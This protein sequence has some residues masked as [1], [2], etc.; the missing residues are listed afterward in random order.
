MTATLVV[1]NVVMAIALWWKPRC[2]VFAFIQC[3][4][5]LEIYPMMYGNSR[6]WMIWE[7][8]N[9][10]IGLI[11]IYVTYDLKVARWLILLWCFIAAN[12]HFDKDCAFEMVI[13]WETHAMDYLNYVILLT[14]LVYAFYQP[15]LRLRS[16][17]ARKPLY[18]AKAPA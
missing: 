9:I 16:Y 14:L 7:P 1:L 3:I 4:Q 6:Q 13:N 18:T 10:I 8:L 12:Y 5:L 11:S 2:K 17:L 15:I